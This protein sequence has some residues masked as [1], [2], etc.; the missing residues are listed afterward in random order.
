M[1]DLFSFP[2]RLPGWLTRTLD[3]LNRPVASGP[4]ESLNV[5]DLWHAM[6][7]GLAAGVLVPVTVLAARYWK[8]VPG[9]DWPRVLNHRGWQIVHTV[10]G[11]GAVLCL[12]VGA[13]MAFNGMSLDVHLIHPHA[14]AGWSVISLVV[15][16]LINIALRGS[17]GGPGRKQARTLVHLHDVPGDHYDMTRRRRIFERLHRLLGYLLVLAL[18]ITLLSGFWHANAPRWLWAL[19]LSWWLTLAI[20]A[21]RWERQGRAVDGYQARWGPGMN[22]PGNRIPRVSGGLRRYTEDEYLALPWGGARLGR[23]P[24]RVSPDDPPTLLLEW[25]PSFNEAEEAAERAAEPDAGGEGR[26]Q[27]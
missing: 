6:L 13:Y 1:A 23:N 24:D 16:L 11:V 9:Q 17:I 21:S 7:M 18:A 8:I 22:H 10:C 5:L 27:G 19:T 14:W 12:F 2:F 25:K 20:V 4:V 15:L 26:R 3:W